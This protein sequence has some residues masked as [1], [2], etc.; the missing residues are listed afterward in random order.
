MVGSSAC[1]KWN[2]ALDGQC[3]H[4]S[5]SPLNRE[6]NRDTEPLGVHEQ[7]SAAALDHGHHISDKLPVFLTSNSL[8][9]SHENS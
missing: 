8:L 4:L 6:L 5:R 3:L 7:G 9:S 1:A 2:E